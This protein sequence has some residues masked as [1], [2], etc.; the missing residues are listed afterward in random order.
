[1]VSGEALGWSIST[2]KIYTGLSN[3]TRNPPVL[4]TDLGPSVSLRLYFTR[5]FQ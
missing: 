1:M 2:S 3:Y 5:C 4:L